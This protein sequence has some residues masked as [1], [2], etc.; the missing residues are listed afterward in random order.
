[1]LPAPEG[2]RLLNDETEEGISD[3]CSAYA[4]RTGNNRIYLGRAI[5]KRMTSLS[6][7]VQDQMRLNQPPEF[8]AATTRDLFLGEIDEATQRSRRRKDQKKD[9]AS[10]IGEKLQVQLKSKAQWDRWSI[11]L[12]STLGKIIGARGI[13]LSY[14]I[15]VNDDPIIDPNKIYEEQAIEG[16]PTAGGDFEQDTATVHSFILRNITE[17]SDAYAYI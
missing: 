1:M 6:H 17:D 15:R 2:L 10:L 11:E 14:V 12:E 5:V 9:G 16:A 8:A 13:P 3:A 7:W 4:R